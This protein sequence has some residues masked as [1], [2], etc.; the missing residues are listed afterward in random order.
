MFFRCFDNFYARK[1]TKK[2]NKWQEFYWYKILYFGGNQILKQ[3]KRRALLTYTFP[4]SKVKD[5]LIKYCFTL[6]SKITFSYIIYCWWKDAKLCSCQEIMTFEQEAIIIVFNLLCQG[7]S[8]F[9]VSGDQLNIIKSS[10]TC[11]KARDTCTLDLFYIANPNSLGN[12]KFKYRKSKKN[13]INKKGS[14]IIPNYN[15]S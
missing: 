11:R 3:I 15:Y 5:D 7:D 6:H 8:V 12:H 10:C 9:K 2:E 1:T 13:H 4:N 14:L